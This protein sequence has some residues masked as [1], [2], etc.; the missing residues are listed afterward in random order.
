MSEREPEGYVTLRVFTN[1]HEHVAA[2]YRMLSRLQAANIACTTHFFESN[3]TAQLCHSI[4]VRADDAPRAKEV[5][6]Y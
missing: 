6:G 5:L 3:L 2:S 4:L 1:T